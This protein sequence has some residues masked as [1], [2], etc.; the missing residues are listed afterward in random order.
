M[1]LETILNV[2]ENEEFQVK[3]YTGRFKVGISKVTGRST[4]YRLN[5]LWIAIDPVDVLKIIDGAPDNII[6]LSKVLLDED[7]ELLNACITLGYKYLTKDLDGEVY[8]S[9]DRPI[10]SKYVWSDGG[11]FIRMRP[12]YSICNLVSS[13]DE[14]PMNIL[15]KLEGRI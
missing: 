12:E 8:A 1:R 14:I 3:G 11:K 13:D 4:L 5:G 6:Y 7:R 10:K 9:K 2:L 15:D